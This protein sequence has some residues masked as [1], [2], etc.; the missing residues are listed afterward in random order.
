MF[1]DK[2]V[3]ARIPYLAPLMSVYKLFLNLRETIS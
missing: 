3:P 1:L 2:T